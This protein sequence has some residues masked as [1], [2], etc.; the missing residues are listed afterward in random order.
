MDPLYQQALIEAASNLIRSSYPGSEASAVS[1]ILVDGR[2]LM[3]PIPAAPIQKK[4]D[5]N[6]NKITL[7]LAVLSQHP[8]W[9][10]AKIAEE[11]GCHVGSLSNSAKFREARRLIKGL[12]QEDINHDD[13][14]D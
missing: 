11:A 13:F 4:T 14:I 9:S 6:V 7:A 10:N 5:Q 3:L 8:D 1:V 12:G 2:Q